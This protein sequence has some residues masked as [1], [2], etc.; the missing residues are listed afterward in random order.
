MQLQHLAEKIPMT[1]VTD[2]SLDREVTGGYSSDLLSDVIAKA[3]AGSIWVTNQAH[4]NVAA[5]AVLI[6]AAAVVVAGGISPD[7]ELVA[8]ARENNVCLFVSDLPAFEI[9]GRLYS[10]GVVGKVND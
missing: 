7:A 1:L 3:S 5:V 2:V 9:V 6:D 10:L 4:Q 8:K